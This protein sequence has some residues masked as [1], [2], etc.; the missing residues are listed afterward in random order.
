MAKPIKP[1]VP[2]APLRSQPETFAERAEASVV[3]WDPFATY[4]DVVG[5]F[6]QEQ[7]ELA[8]AAAV[9]GDLPPLVGQ[10]LKF[11]RVNAAETGVEFSEVVAEVSSDETPQLGGNLDTNGKMIFQSTG[12]DVVAAAELPLLADGMFNTVTGSDDITSMA[13]VGVGAVK[14]L[15]FTNS[16]TLAHHATDLKLIGDADVSIQA[17]DKATLHEYAEGAWEMTGL[18][19]MVGSAAVLGHAYAEITDKITLAPSFP[20]DDTIPQND[21]GTEIGTLSITPK[22]LTSRLR[23]SVDVHLGGANQTARAVGIWVNDEVDARRAAYTYTEWASSTLTT[24][25]YEY[26]PTSL[27]PQTISVRAGTVGSGN[28]YLN[29][30]QAGQHKFGASMFSTISITEFSE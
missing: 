12:A 13:G 10:A 28:L 1:V 14:V 20:N 3:F 22:S 16:L 26:T 29:T 17:G 24:L 23:I 15:T 30:N 18:V 2:P 4:L 11:L 8:L 19:R 9:G 27:D 5:D 25:I 7:A 21:E 6:T